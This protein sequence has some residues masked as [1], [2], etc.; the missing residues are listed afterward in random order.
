MKTGKEIIPIIAMIVLLIGTASTLYVHATQINK[1]TITINGQEFSI[2]Q[3]FSMV[4]TKTIETNEGE[5]T[6]IALDDLMIKVGIGCMSC[7]NYIIK[8]KDKYQQTVN[9]DVMKTGILT[10]YSR[11]YFPDTAHTFWV[12]DVIVIEVK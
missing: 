5:K 3:L 4:D 6:G 2:D 10:D 1:D 12:R 9:W 7:N 11:V 8:A